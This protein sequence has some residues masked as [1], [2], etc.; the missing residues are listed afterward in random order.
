MSISATT[1]VASA[2]TANAI[3][4][5]KQANS[6]QKQSVTTL[7]NSVAQTAPSNQ[8]QPPHIGNNINVK[9]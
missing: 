1:S 3:Y 2:G 9:A 8:G 6:I 4:A 5:Q 7:L